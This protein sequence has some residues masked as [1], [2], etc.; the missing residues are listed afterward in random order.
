MDT[1]IARCIGDYVAKC[2]K[3]TEGDSQVE[4]DPKLEDVVNRMFE[5]CFADGE[6]NQAV[7]IALEARRLDVVER[8]IVQSQ[9]IEEMMRYTY[10]IAQNL[11]L[12]KQFRNQVLQLLLRIY[13]KATGGVYDYFSLCKCQFFLNVPEATA[14]LLSRLLDAPG[15]R[16]YLVAY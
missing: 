10:S 7:G 6:F 16:D 11:I 9:R 15:E 8:A 14:S 3:K 2:A 12:S 1:L 5:R 13:E 4:I